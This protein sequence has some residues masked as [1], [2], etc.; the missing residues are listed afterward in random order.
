MRFSRIAGLVTGYF[1]YSIVLYPTLGLSILIT[2]PLHKAPSDVLI[3]IYVLSGILMGLFGA[4]RDGTCMSEFICGSAIYVLLA[5]LIVCIAMAS[6]SLT[7]MP[8]SAALVVALGPLL[9][10]L[11]I[12][13][14]YSIY[15]LWERRHHCPTAKQLQSHHSV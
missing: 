9:Q 3:H 1:I 7:L 15:A 5:T 14:G 12:G 4:Y 2:A 8:I 10:C 11:C 13:V 6:I